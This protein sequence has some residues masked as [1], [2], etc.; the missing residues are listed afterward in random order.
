M[1]GEDLLKRQVR[2]RGRSQRRRY[3]PV[4]DLDDVLDTLSMLYWRTR[5]RP[6]PLEELQRKIRRQT[7]RKTRRIHHEQKMG[8]WNAKWRIETEHVGGKTR[9]RAVRKRA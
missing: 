2:I 3:H 6:A 5:V 9:N 1:D 8:A 4:N 7:A